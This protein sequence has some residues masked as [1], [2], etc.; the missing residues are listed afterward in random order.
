M[1]TDTRASYTIGY[2]FNPGSAILLATEHR[3]RVAALSAS[4]TSLAAAAGATTALFVNL[5]LQE[6]R[7]GEYTFD[8]T[9]TM[10][11]C[12]S[13]LVAVTAGCG[14]IENWAAVAIGG[15]SGLI[16]LGGSTFLIKIKL[17]DAVDAIPVHLFN[18][19]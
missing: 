11:G 6:R 2:G 17:D 7:T 13:G 12:L 8:L 16:Y 14:T 3:G 10:N 5:Y 9:K 18:G 4:N 1:S 15:V 19:T